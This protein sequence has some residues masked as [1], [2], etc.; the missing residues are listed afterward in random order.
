MKIRVQVIVDEVD[1]ERFRRHAEEAGQSLSS[2]LRQAG[3]ERAAAESGRKRHRT[4]AELRSFFDATAKREDAAGE[5]EPEWAEH[6]AVIERSIG[7]GA[8]DT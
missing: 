7:S 2:W 8:A 1:R 6:R 4:V 3:R 5:R